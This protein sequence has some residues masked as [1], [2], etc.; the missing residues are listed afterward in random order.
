MT[1]LKADTEMYSSKST[2]SCIAL[3]S[4]NVATALKTYLDEAR[5]YKLC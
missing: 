5:S 4:L 3:R 2:E 1:L